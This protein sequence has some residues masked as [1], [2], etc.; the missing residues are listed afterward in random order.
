VSMGGRHLA[1][2][3]VRGAAAITPRGREITNDD[4]TRAITAARAGLPRGENR[5][6]LHEIPR[7]YLVD[8]QIGVR[9]PHGMAGY[10]LEVEVHY[11][12]G[13]ATMV[14]N[15][16]KCVRQANVRPDLVVATP[17]AAG[18]AVRDA[19]G[20]ATRLGGLDIGEETTRVAVYINDAIWLSEVLRM[21]GLHFTQAIGARLRLPMP[22]AEELKIRH[23]HCDSQRVG[24]T[25]LVD[26]PEV[27]GVEALLP[28]S[29]VV[30]ALAEQSE[31]FA[32]VVSQR[33]EAIRRSEVVP[34]ALLLVGGG[35]LLPG[36]EVRLMH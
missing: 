36:V 15:V 11:T 8:G 31:A 22:T 16:L 14:H 17:L 7:A 25:E 27:A 20:D 1:S 28:R 3:N 24:E 21:G 10:E 34:E 6:V 13:A 18:E 32:E 30:A 35:A 12:T 29:E 2:Q 19:Y 23:G 33:L 5:E 4:V 26:M 9:D